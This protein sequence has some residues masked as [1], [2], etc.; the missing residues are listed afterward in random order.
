MGDVDSVNQ[1][2][3]SHHEAADVCPDANILSVATGEDCCC[4]DLAIVPL[5]TAETKFTLSLGPVRAHLDQPLTASQKDFSSDSPSPAN[6]PP[7]YLIT[8]R[9]R[10]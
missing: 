3:A 6:S 9:F 4:G 5:E 10:I 7:V 8:Q 1:G 2:T